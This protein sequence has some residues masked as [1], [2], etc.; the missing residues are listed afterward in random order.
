MRV[1]S[2][3]VVI[4]TILS[5]LATSTCKSGMP[6]ASKSNANANR[7]A[8][9]LEQNMSQ[10]MRNFR[11]RF[12][13]V[14][15]Q[16]DVAELIRVA[17]EKLAN[18]DY[19][20]KDVRLVAAQLLPIQRMR[21]ILWRLK[22]IVE[23]QKALHSTILTSMMTIATS[24]RIFAPQG[25]ADVDGTYSW[26]AVNR[27]FAWPYKGIGAQFQTVEQFQTFLL[28]EVAPSIGQASKVLEE[29]SIADSEPV[30]WDNALIYGRGSFGGSYDSKDRYV[31]LYEGE[32]LMIL[33]GLAAMRHNLLFFAQYNYDQ[34][35]QYIGDLA[36]LVGVDTVRWDANGIS[37]IDRA[38]KLCGESYPNGGCN[39]KYP[40][41]F[42]KRGISVMSEAKNYLDQSVNYLDLAWKDIKRRGGTS[43][44]L[45]DYQLL[46]PAKLLPWARITDANINNLKLLIAG[47]PVHNVVTGKL[48]QVDF[49]KFYSQPPQDLKEFVPTAFDPK[50][51]TLTVDGVDNVRNY[52]FGM[53]TQW[54]AQIYANYFPPINGTPQ[55][56]SGKEIPEI[57]R[58]L[59]QTWG[60]WFANAPL[61][62]VSMVF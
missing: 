27:Y 49:P 52:E 58:D 8:G 30:V 61:A 4:G 55:V 60:G 38:K 56:A 19:K 3:G 50:P 9:N 14:K 35:P 31:T 47:Q 7:S 22:P 2:N 17:A 48:V 6:G 54:N 33:S 29:M 32:K 11:D 24:S 18:G 25:A 59:S 20:D 40:Q 10:D 43:P 57:M 41:L 37:A 36:Y 44:S 15:D 34:L 28:Q 62:T 45:P 12:V 1:L 39:A 21:G 53:S 46:D 5:V 13:N 51:R 16:N 26:K 42:T 23:T